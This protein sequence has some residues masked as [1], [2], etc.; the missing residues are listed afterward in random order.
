MQGIIPTGLG[1]Y[2]RFT[3]GSTSVA[4]TQNGIKTACRSGK[5]LVDRQVRPGNPRGLAREGLLEWNWSFHPQFIM[6]NHQ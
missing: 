4:R 6:R 5:A 1:A 2:N 3:L